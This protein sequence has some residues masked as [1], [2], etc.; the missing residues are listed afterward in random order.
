MRQRHC[1]A[2]A[3]AE[4]CVHAPPPPLR[5]AR[6][7]IR[8]AVGGRRTGPSNDGCYVRVSCS[9]VSALAKGGGQAVIVGEHGRRECRLLQRRWRQQ[10]RVTVKRVAP[11]ARRCGLCSASHCPCA[12]AARSAT[13][14]WRRLCSSTATSAAAPWPFC[15]QRS[16]PCIRS[17]TRNSRTRSPL[18]T[19]TTA[20]ISAST[21]C[22]V[23]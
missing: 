6:P 19:T 1:G 23:A 7:A 22:Q 9:A 21:S 17:P 13:A 16:S 20:S 10:P 4:V 3:E 14:T 15:A 8:L 18:S 12:A 5:C 11:E 2:R